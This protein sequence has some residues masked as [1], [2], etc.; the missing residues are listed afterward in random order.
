MQAQRFV[1]ALFICALISTPF[2]ARAQNAAPAKTLVLIPYQEPTDTAPLGAHVTAM[3]L[4]DLT[5]AGIKPV[6]VAPMDHLDAVADAGRI[7]SENNADGILIPE[8]RSE[9][10]GRLSYFVVAS[11]VTYEWHV[12]F[13][14]DLVDCRG[15]VRRSI[16][17]TGNKSSTGVLSPVS[18]GGANMR[19][20]PLETAFQSAVQSAVGEYVASPTD[21]A[22]ASAPLTPDPV[23]SP[24]LTSKLLLIPVGQPG[25]SDPNAAAVTNAVLT[26]MKQ[27]KLDVT[28]GTEIDYL[29]AFATAEQLC[30]AS[31][32]QGIVIPRLRFF[33]LPFS[34]QSRALFRL[35]LLACNGSPSGYGSGQG[36]L[37][38]APKHDF[39]AAVVEAS[40]QAA[41]PALDQ[42]F[43]ESKS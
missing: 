3:L 42:L 26:Q 11:T 32:A 2:A 24:T 19:A 23:A 21:L 7:C 10:T 17:T 27:R 28:L 22:V 30:A 39:G 8:G 5:T 29:T 36:D 14:L 20:S 33:Q 6:S 37:K 12:D 18:P 40:E 9:V 38:K 15:T 16:L 41:G 4:S 1:A 43:P 31:G 25:L 13:R 34:G 35:N